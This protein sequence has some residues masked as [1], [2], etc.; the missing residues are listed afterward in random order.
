MIRND[1]G[2]RFLSW[3]VGLGLLAL[4]AAALPMLPD[5]VRCQ[6]APKPVAL[7]ARPD[8]YVAD[9]V[10]A[11]DDLDRAEAAL[12]KQLADL[13][14]KREALRK[15]EA[16]SV[17]NKAAAG[18]TTI[19]IEISGLG[20]KPEDLKKLIQQLEKLLPGDKKR[21]IILSGQNTGA[22]MGGDNAA[23]RRIGYPVPVEAG[24]PGLVDRNSNIQW[25]PMTPPGADARPAALEKRLD[26]LLQEIETLRRELRNRQPEKPKGPGFPTTA[27]PARS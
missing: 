18:G 6:E 8:D 16:D 22:M 5:W 23:H 21:V 26:S 20:A 25:R 7:P 19:R 10:K 24:R 27:G 14:L 3:P 13:R 4:A 15:K 2:S 9:L 1:D 12:K 17:R 11:Q